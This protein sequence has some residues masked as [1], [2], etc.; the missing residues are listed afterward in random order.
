M[1]FND[2]FFRPGR[3]SPSELTAAGAPA[4]VVQLNME[5]R[6][7]ASAIKAAF[8]D[9]GDAVAAKVDQEVE[10][11][12]DGGEFERQIQDL[13]H[14]SVHHQLQATVNAS[15]RRAL[16][17]REDMV[18]RITALVIEEINRKESLNGY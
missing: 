15:V 9:Y 18:K 16:S 13:V 5:V 7:M 2:P 10:K 3:N 11:F 8:V 6:A 1:D 14:S 4:P 17:E 12:F